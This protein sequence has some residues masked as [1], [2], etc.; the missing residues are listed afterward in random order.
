MSAHEKQTPDPNAYKP[1][2]FLLSPL[3][4]TTFSSYAYIAVYPQCAPHMRAVAGWLAYTAWQV[5]GTTL[6]TCH[7]VLESQP[8]LAI[9]TEHLVRT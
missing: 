9:H 6:T 8:L 3:A 1:P 7:A 4:C 2:W 5:P